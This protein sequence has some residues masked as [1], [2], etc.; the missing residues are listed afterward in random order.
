MKYR[1]LSIFLTLTLLAGLLPATA[2]A[3]DTDDFYYNTSPEGDTPTVT[4]AGYKGS[5]KNAIIPPILKLP[6]NKA[7][8]VTAIAQGAF[9]GNTTITSVTI[10]NGVTTIE[11]YTFSNCT[12]LVCR[13]FC[14][15]L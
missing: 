14:K 13:T 12:S 10:P 5:G 6:G 8:T 11:G 2:L 9:S 4:I 1:I 7:A 3:L 15:A